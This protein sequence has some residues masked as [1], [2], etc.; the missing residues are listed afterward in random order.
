[1]IQDLTDMQTSPPSTGEMQQALAMLLREIPL[2][3]SSETRIA[4]G[5]LSRAVL[6]LPLDEPVR[7]AE[8]YK[9]LS[10]QQVQA[11]FAKWI[12]PNDFVEVVEGPPAK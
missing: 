6:G 9:S 2:D 1:V 5:F 4:D 3:Q 10:A 11:A 12:R 8:K 7:A